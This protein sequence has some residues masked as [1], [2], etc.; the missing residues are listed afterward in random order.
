VTNNPNE[1]ATSVAPDH[2]PVLTRFEL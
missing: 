2:A 1:R